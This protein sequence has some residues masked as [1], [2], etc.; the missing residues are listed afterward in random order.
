MLNRPV[1]LDAFGQF[2]LSTFLCLIAMRL[3]FLGPL[4]AV[5]DEE[6]DWLRYYLE[7]STRWKIWITRFADKNPEAYWSRQYAGQIELTPPPPD[8]VG[9][10]YCNTHI[11]TLVIGHLCA[12][13][14]YSH[15][16]SF[17]GYEGIHLTR[18][19]PPTG[20]DIDSRAMPTINADS[21]L[22]LHEAF[23]RERK[24]IRKKV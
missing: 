20:H 15:I 23:A 10:E 8:K 24:L 21:A 9:P 14:F 13:T 11:S 5:P 19:W 4:Q 2:A 22:W 1:L 7:P 17:D 18:I 3:E 16:M 6:R 12:H